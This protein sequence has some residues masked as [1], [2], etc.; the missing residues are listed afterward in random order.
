M[1]S[2]IKNNDDILLCNLKINRLA[3]YSDKEL[4]KHPKEG[5]IKLS[6]L[7][8]RKSVF[9]PAEVKVPLTIGSFLVKLNANL[10]ME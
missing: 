1:Y 8:Q 4:K 5:E 2:N 7:D 10:I 9:F 6:I 3:G